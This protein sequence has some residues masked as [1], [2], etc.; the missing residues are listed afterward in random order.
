MLRLTKNIIADASTKQ[1]L[2]NLTNSITRDLLAHKDTRRDFTNLVVNV[3]CGVL[4]G[5]FA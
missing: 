2:Q 3:R 4:C 5:S 1:Y